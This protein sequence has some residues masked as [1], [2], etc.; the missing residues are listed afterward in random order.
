MWGWC[1]C[2]GGGLGVV[3]DSNTHSTDGPDGLGA[4]IADLADLDARGVA[5]ADQGVQVA[6]EAEP[7]LLEAARRLDPPR[8]R[9]AVA[10]LRLVADPD[11]ADRD[12]EHRHQRRGCG[13]LRPGR[14]WWR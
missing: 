14:G 11:A 1:L 7:V 12:R 10:H 3:V 13:W 4:V 2:S 8:L 9:R 5:G 6:A